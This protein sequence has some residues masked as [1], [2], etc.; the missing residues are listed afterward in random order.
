[1]LRNISSYQQLHLSEISVWWNQMKPVD[2]GRWQLHGRPCG[3][4]FLPPLPHHICVILMWLMCMMNHGFPSKFAR[5]LGRMLRKE[6]CLLN[7]A[8][9][10]IKAERFEI[11][12][13]IPNLTYPY[14][15]HDNSL[16]PVHSYSI[17]VKWLLWSPRSPLVN[18]KISKTFSIIS[19]FTQWCTN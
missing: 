5:G 1:M 9:C 13:Q 8:L 19:W 16:Y 18:A 12:N 3:P 4:C 2:L 11:W 17:P 6:A 10:L 14:I 15:S 7:R